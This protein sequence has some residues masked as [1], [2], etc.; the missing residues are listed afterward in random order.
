MPKIPEMDIARMGRTM[1]VI[2]YEDDKP[3][4]KRYLEQ[5]LED[6]DA[7]PEVPTDWDLSFDEYLEE[8]KNSRLLLC[9]YGHMQELFSVLVT[10]TVF[11]GTAR[12]SQG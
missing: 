11:G 12:G 7:E 10:T 4:I 1:R 8:H 6:P 3:K 2:E 9:W 5:R